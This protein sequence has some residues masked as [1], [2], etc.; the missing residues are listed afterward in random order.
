VGDQDRLLEAN[1]RFHALLERLDIA[2]EYVV[3]PGA[4]HSY[5]QKAAW[6]GLEGFRFFARAFGDA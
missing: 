2:H 6:M 5:D 1:A 4:E 3:V